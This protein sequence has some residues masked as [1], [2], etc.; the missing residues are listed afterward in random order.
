MGGAHHLQLKTV[1]PHSIAGIGLLQPLTA[2]ADALGGKNAGCLGHDERQGR[3]AVRKRTERL[4]IHMVGVM[5]GAEHQID[6]AER[7]GRH[8]RRRHPVMRMGMA[9][10]FGG[11]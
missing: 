5:V 7:I 9:A 10:I 6:G 4:A 2:D 11:E 8:R 3:Q 1:K